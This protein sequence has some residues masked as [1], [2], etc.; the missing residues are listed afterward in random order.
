MTIFG[1]VISYVCRTSK[2]RD[3]FVK[4]LGLASSHNYWAQVARAACQV[5]LEKKKR[6]DEYMETIQ[7][8]KLFAD[9][10]MFDKCRTSKEEHDRP[11]RTDCATLGKLVASVSSDNDS[12]ITAGFPVH[13]TVRLKSI[14]RN[15]IH[16]I[17]Y[18]TTWIGFCT[19]FCPGFWPF[20]SIRNATDAVMEKMR[21][22]F[23]RVRFGDVPTGPRATS[24]VSVGSSGPR[25]VED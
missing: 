21:L 6:D 15:H 20:S 1:E 22:K 2:N 12:A 3:E 23:T 4:D 16:N 17:L 19:A 13:P 14:P 11:S 24:V 5:P 10:L 18:T 8:L 9:G 25:R 7:P